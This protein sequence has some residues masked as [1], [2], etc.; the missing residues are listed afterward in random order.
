[1]AN[2]AT[3]LLAPSV[4]ARKVT[5]GGA[6]SAA[7]TYAF[8]MFGIR[9]VLLGADLLS[10]DPQVRAHAVRAALPIHASDVSTVAALALRRKISGRAAALLGGISA[11]NVALALRA[12]R[13]T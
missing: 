5:D 3:G 4:L 6:T 11:V 7:A 9:T 8:R 10:R 13:P 12:R 2:G 1:M